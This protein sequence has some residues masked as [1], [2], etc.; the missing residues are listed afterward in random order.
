MSVL[1]WC[2]ECD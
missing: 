1:H 2:N